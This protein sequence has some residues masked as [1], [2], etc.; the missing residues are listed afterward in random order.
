MLKTLQDKYIDSDIKLLIEE[1]VLTEDMGIAK[2]WI[3][4]AF[5][6]DKFKKELGTYVRGIVEREKKYKEIG[7]C[8]NCTSY[9]AIRSNIK[10]ISKKGKEYVHTLNCTAIATSRMLRTILE[11]YQQ[12]DGS[13]KVPTV[14][15]KYTG[16]KKIEK[17]KKRVK[18]KA[19]KKR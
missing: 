14:L 13:I 5:I 15:Q 17:E 8:S 9:Q 7:S 2:R 3:I 1:G 18:K 19:R 11:N 6:V 16:F 12:K 4:E 10:Y